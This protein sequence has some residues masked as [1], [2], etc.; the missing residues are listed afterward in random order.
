MNDLRHSQNSEPAAAAA[1]D[2][3]I[4][5]W[6]G[7]DDPENPYNWSTAKKYTTLAPISAIT[8]IMFVYIITDE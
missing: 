4:V 8:F 2:A 1:H 6:D 7:P 3:L 5:G